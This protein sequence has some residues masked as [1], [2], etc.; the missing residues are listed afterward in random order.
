M[1]KI[2]SP[3]TTHYGPPIASHNGLKVQVCF[4]CGYKHLAPLPNPDTITRFYADPDGF[5]KDAEQMFRIDANHHHMGLWD[6][7][8]RWETTQLFTHL[9]PAT[10]IIDLGA[11]T[12]WFVKWWADNIGRAVGVEPSPVA[13]SNSPVPARLFPTLPESARKFAGGNP[14]YLRA[15]LVL[16]HLVD[17]VGFLK[18]AVGIPQRVKGII[19]TTPNE[20]NPLQD[21]IVKRD[22]VGNWFIDKTHINYFDKQGLGVVLREAGFEPLGWYATHPLE[23]WQLAG[24]K[25]IGDDQKGQRV[26]LARLNLEKRLG[27]VAFGLYKILFDRLGWGREII[28]V[29]KLRDTI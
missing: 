22:G 4:Q 2:A 26:H 20:W 7:L 28:C 29:A 25:Y 11:G 9:G 5:Y 3:A 19:V 27:R 13:R 8:Y 15:R 14:V 21:R 17:P 1:V 18:E 6:P 24:F 10:R 16:E 12:G 23:L